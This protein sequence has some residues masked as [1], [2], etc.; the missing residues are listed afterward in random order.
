MTSSNFSLKEVSVSGKAW[1]VRRVFYW[2]YR[3]W[4]AA[5]RAYWLHSPIYKASVNKS[6]VG[7]FDILIG[8]LDINI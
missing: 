7:F 1:N 6:V 8:C 5:A 3:V 2:I 4:D